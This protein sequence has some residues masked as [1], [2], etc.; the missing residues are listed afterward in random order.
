M[1]RSF[2]R[3][4]L[5]FEAS[6]VCIEEQRSLDNPLRFDSSINEIFL[7]KGPVSSIR[8]RWRS[9]AS[10]EIHIPFHTDDQAHRTLA[11]LQQWLHDLSSQM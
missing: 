6:L 10:T 7:E 5:D 9:D 1:R 3:I 8:L 4:T 11:Q 2:W